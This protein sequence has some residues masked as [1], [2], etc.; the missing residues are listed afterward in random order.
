TRSTAASVSSPTKRYPRHCGCLYLHPDVFPPQELILRFLAPYRLQQFERHSCPSSR[1]LLAPSLQPPSGAT[2]TYISEG[3]SLVSPSAV[4]D[5]S[6]ICYD[7]FK[8]QHHPH[9]VAV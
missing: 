6:V 8:N 4:L 2:T 3:I 5:P 7:G 9:S 1:P